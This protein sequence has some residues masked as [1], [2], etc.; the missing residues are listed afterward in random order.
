MKDSSSPVA[1][2]TDDADIFF[3]FMAGSHIFNLKKFSFKNIIKDERWITALV[4][5]KIANNIAEFGIFS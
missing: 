3:I 2:K 5:M 1:N 4:K